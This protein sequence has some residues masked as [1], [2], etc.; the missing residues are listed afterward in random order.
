MKVILKQDV[1]SLG[2]RGDVVTVARGY[3]RNY[4]LP[5]KLALEVTAA[6]VK[7]I[8]IERRAIRK[9]VEK[10]RQS[11]QTVIE[12]LNRTTLSFNRKTGEKD[13]LFGSVSAADIKEELDRMG[14]EIDRKKILLDEPIKKLGEFVV[15]IKVF[16][17]D[18]A[19]VRLVVHSETEE[20]PEAAKAAA[21]PDVPDVPAVPEESTVPDTKPEE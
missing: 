10:E 4:L 1:E 20:K 12:K 9:R 19:E 3:G 14:I 7:S 2:R 6:N 5:R 13:T 18:K 16:H 15:P 17:D 21:T 8:E 11:F